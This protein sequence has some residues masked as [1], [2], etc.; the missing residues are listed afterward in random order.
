MDHFVVKPKPIWL[1]IAQNPNV[2]L[3]LIGILIVGVIGYIIYTRSESVSRQV[4]RLLDRP[5][6]SRDAGDPDEERARLAKPQVNAFQKSRPSDADEEASTKAGLG[7][8]TA[9]AG[10]SA[11]EK[12]EDDFG[13]VKLTG[14]H[15]VEVTHWEIPRE[16]V[17]N[18]IALADRIGDGREGRAYFFANGS[19]IIDQIQSVAQR[20]SLG[21]II[22]ARASEQMTT[23]TP[24]TTGEAFQFGFFIAV[25][26]VEGKDLGLKWVSQL[27]L[28]QSE[29]PAEQA[30]N[31]PSLRSLIQTN[32]SGQATLTTASLL[33]IVMEPANRAPREELLLRAGEGPW[34]VF[35]SPDFRGGATDWIIA[36]QIR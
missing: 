3:S 36:I 19:K 26:K 14:A 32:M 35:A 10:L 9:G 18:L 11:G 13:A 5:V 24:P 34:T 1:R 2:H 8:A 20:L 6:S 27:V 7:A 30:S 33:M 28:P 22:P 25:N 15:K 21:R 17:A 23:E 16:V 31:Q 4:D 12:V 29:T